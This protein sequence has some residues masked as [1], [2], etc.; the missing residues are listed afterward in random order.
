MKTKKAFT[1]IE[2]LVV[3]AII[4]LLATLSVLALQN[5]RINSRDAKRLADV[6][7]LR[8]ALELYYNDAGHYPTADEFNSG[9]IEYYTPGVGTSTYMMQVPSAPTPADG[10]CSNAENTYTYLPDTNGSTY[11]LN[12]CIAKNNGDLPAGGLIAHPG[13]LTWL[14][15]GSGGETGGETSTDTFE[16]LIFYGGSAQDNFYDVAADGDYVYS[17]GTSGQNFVVT[18]FNKDLTVNLQK[19]YACPSCWI[20][21]EGGPR[22]V[23][24]GNYIFVAANYANGG[25]LVKVNKNTLD[26]EATE[27]M[28]D[29]SPTSATFYSLAVDGS[30]VY[31]IGEGQ[32]STG[33]YGGLIAKFNKSDLSYVSQKVLDNGP[34]TRFSFQGGGVDD[35]YLYAVGYVSNNTPGGIVVK[36]NKSDLS[37]I[38]QKYYGGTAY[39]ADVLLTAIPVGNYVYVLG[40]GRNDVP[41][42]RDSGYI[43]KY[44]I[45]D[46]SIAAKRYYG[47]LSQE[48]AFSNAFY[49]GSNIYGVGTYYKYGT[50]MF[51][52]VLKYNLSDLS[53]AGKYRI[54]ISGC[55]YPKFLGG[56]ADATNLYFS[57]N[58]Y[59]SCGLPSG[60][61]FIL[62]KLKKSNLETSAVTDPSKLTWDAEVDGA[63]SDSTSTIDGD[64][65]A[66][67]LASDI[68]HGSLI[69]DAST[70][71]ISVLS[72]YIINR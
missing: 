2:L 59:G 48:Y 61:D 36:C 45:S 65:S 62:S 7:Q 34:S 28:G 32:G 53:V 11:V 40:W 43:I 8:S 60:S 18:K 6:K 15:A 72:S 3:I 38:S 51:A 5:A 16:G 17:A 47:M 66:S 19:S 68:V 10:S 44:N 39:S 50:G 57:S 29:Y 21:Y 42:Q 49:D 14:G 26:L 23:V 70:V 54:S 24:D 52:E 4:G 20:N 12:F 58:T 71:D 37:V 9:K 63:D 56:S 67:V 41:G 35:N 33:N 1:L 27:S 25:M 64:V 69:M 13:G 30:S 55:T 46:M 31:A 22:I